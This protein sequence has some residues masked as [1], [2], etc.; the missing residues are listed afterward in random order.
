MNRGGSFADSE[1]QRARSTFAELVEHLVDAEHQIA[2]R[3]AGES[4][5][6]AAA[7]VAVERF[8]APRGAVQHL[9]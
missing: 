6:K 2:F 8:A 5:Q 3:A 1:L 7:A 9:T 4:L